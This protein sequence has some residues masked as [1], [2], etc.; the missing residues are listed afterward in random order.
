MTTGTSSGCATSWRF[1][2]TLVALG[3]LWRVL[4]AALT[5]VP[6]EDGANYLWMA[7]RFA[8]GDAT[9]ALSEV[10]PPLMPLTL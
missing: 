10:F 8:A 1:V 2:W 7:E 5:V 3:F 6:S 4:I 9:G